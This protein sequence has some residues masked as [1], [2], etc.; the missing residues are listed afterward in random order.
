MPT[1]ETSICN[2]ALQ[3]LGEARIVSLSEDS[4]T[5]RE[6]EA[7]YE[8]MRDKELRANRWKFAIKRTTLAPS[9][10]APDFYYENAFVL[11]ADCLRPIFPPL[12]DIDWK[13]ENHLGEPAILTNDGDT[14][15]LRYVAKITD[16][17][18]FDALFVDSLACR[19]AWQLCERITQSNSKK[20]LI[21]E[22]YRISIQEAKKMNAIEIGHLIAP[23]DEW[24]SG[25]LSGQLVNSEWR[26]E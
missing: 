5:A 26:Q 12:L 25:R 23:Q 11:P 2:L 22:E 10:T 13:V 17:T 19:I 4:N 3:K 1:S 18:I 21:Y 20:Q 16:P 7:A 24:I 8:P 9:A 6:C 14:L 15:Q